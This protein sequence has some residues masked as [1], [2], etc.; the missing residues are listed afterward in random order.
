MLVNEPI[1]S[2]EDKA[3]FLARIQT[4]LTGLTAPAPNQTHPID[5]GDDIATASESELF[6]ILDEDV[7][8]R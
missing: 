4:I 8:P 6:A 2:P 3:H 5:H 1:W 7:G